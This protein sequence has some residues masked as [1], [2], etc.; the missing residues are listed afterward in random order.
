MATSSAPDLSK[1]ALS[2]L[3]SQ[4]TC[5]ICLDRYKDPRALPCTHSYCKDCIS[6][7]PVERPRERQ[8]VVKC[9]V[10]QQPAQLGENGSS[11][12]P[13][14][15][16]INNL[17]EID[18]LLKKVPTHGN[19]DEHKQQTRP[20]KNRI[21]EVEQ[22]LAL[23]DSREREMRKVEE[24]VQKDIDNGYQTLMSK[25]EESRIRLSQEA[26]A[27]LQKKMKLHL[28]QKANVETVMARMKSC[29]LK[30]EE[31]SLSQAKSAKAD[32]FKCGMQADMKQLSITDTHSER[33]KVSEL[34]PTQELNIMFM[35]DKNTL[36]ACGHIGEISS[37]Q[38]SNSFL[39]DLP[40]RILVDRKTMVAIKGPISLEASQLS[41]KLYTSKE[42]SFSTCPVTSVGEG[43]FMVMIW[44][45]T[46]GLRQLRVLVD[47]VDIYGSPFSVRVVEW[48]KKSCVYEFASIGNPWDVAVT[49]DGQ[50]VVVSECTGN[51]VTVLSKYLF[52]SQIVRNF[53]GFGGRLKRPKSLAVSADCKNI[54]VATENGIEKYS[55]L[56]SA[57]EGSFAIDCNGL[58]LHPVSGKVYCIDKAKKNIVVLNNDLTSS[59]VLNIKMASSVMPACID[60]AIDSKGMLYIVCCS[61][62]V[63]KFTP[64]GE[65]YATISSFGNQDYQFVNP[66]CI[67]IDS[68]DI[69]YVTDVHKC[70][71]MMFT[72]E[73]EYLGNLCA[74]NDINSVQKCELRGVA[75]DKTGKLFLCNN[76]GQVLYFE[77]Q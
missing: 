18:E 48:R 68:N 10:C 6:R 11:G 1:E 42:S 65:Y 45:G 57:Y 54:F 43:Q 41:C 28:S 5:A 27:T 46:V 69:M 70:H 67:C 40:T 50:Y 32:E 22:A 60:L 16:H 75:V 36:S 9:P 64:E 56:T 3:Q 44:C 61:G 19:V 30:E 49:D 34:M 59:H 52:S 8:R 4:L 29:K 53:A 31:E 55:L 2:K 77:H 39:V 21:D 25:L 58:A 15:F 47:G 26:S 71:I 74:Y 17:L 66:G 73:G 7:F 12:L 23:F 24:A 14:A 33:V 35:L 62:M 72:T 63:L 76:N 38:L 20:A 51:C 37:K 13:I